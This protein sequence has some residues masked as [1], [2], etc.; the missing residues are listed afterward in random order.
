VMPEGFAFPESQ[1]IWIPLRLNGSTLAPLAGP[2][3]SVFGRLAPGTSIENTRAELDVIGARMAASHPETHEHLRPRV[4]AYAK[5][6]LEG[7]EA[8][9]VGRLMDLANG[10]FLMLLAVVCANVATL[11]FART[12]TRG[13]EIAV[14]NALGA[15]RGRIVAQL[16]LEALV[17]ASVA[18]A[19]GLIVA[20]SA[21]RWGLSLLAGNEIPFWMTDSLSWATM[22]YAALLTL[23]GAAIVGVLPALRITKLNVQDSL[24]SENAAGAALRFGGFWTTVIVMQVAI[25][26]AFLPLA[27]GG[28]FQSNRFAQRAEGIGAERYIAASVAMDREDHA[29]D[30]A[31]F[32]ARAR[33]SIAELERRLSAEPGVEQVAFADR[34]PVMDQFKY[35]IELDRRP[36]DRHTREHAGPRVARFLCRLWHL[37]DCRSRL[38]ATRLRNRPRSDR[39]RIVYATRVWRPQPDRSAHPHRER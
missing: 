24:R 3:V 10:I 34:L 11:V 31:V 38:R 2:A 15:S 14:R 22:L 36:P 4:T 19:V 18:A 17:L 28:V 21:R 33:S 20:K 8:L 6:I 25:T 29:A 12:A 9:F 35:Q 27:A 16:F 32:D 1:R 39:Q 13:W 37:G 23:F 7:G 26:V 30:S 5:P